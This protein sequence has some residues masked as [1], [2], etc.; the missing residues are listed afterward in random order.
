[1]AAATAPEGKKKKK[2]WHGE[3]TRDGLKSALGIKRKPN[4][5]DRERARAKLGLPDPAT[6]DRPFDAGKTPKSNEHSAGNAAGQT[7][8]PDKTAREGG[9]EVAGAKVTKAA[10]WDMAKDNLFLK[11]QIPETAAAIVRM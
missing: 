2:R 3:M 11:V 4:R 5:K 10:A 8:Q 7:K 9:G 1:M 6:A